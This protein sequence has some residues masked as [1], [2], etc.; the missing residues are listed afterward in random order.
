M[1]RLV[2]FITRHPKSVIAFTLLFIG[3][4][5]APL[6]R[7]TIDP[8]MLSLIDQNDPDLV[9]MD[10]IDEIFGGQDIAIISVAAENAF[11]PRILQIVDSLTQAIE[12]MDYVDRVTSIT[13]VEIIRGANDFMSVDPFLEVI[14]SSQEEQDSLGHLAAQE[15][16][17]QD[18]L[19]SDDQ[20]HTAILVFL[21]EGGYDEV[22]YRQF[23]SFTDRYQSEDVIIELGGMPIIRY[24]ISADIEHDVVTFIPLGMSLMVILLFFS[25]RSWRGVLLPMGVVAM[26]IA[27]TLGLM[28]WLDISLKIVTNLVP[29]MLIAI[30]NAYG[31]HILARYYEDV[32]EL[33]AGAPIHDII[34]R[35]IKHI[36][37]PILLA[38]V[39][40]IAGFLSLLSHVLPASREVGILSAFGIA[41]SFILS[42]T[43]IPAVLTLLRRPSATENIHNDESRYISRV[44]SH[45]GDAVYHHQK[46][47]LT[48]FIGLTIIAA[49]GI[50][51]IVVDSNPLNYYEK[52]SEIHRISTVINENYGGSSS[53]SVVVEGDIREPVVLKQIEAIQSYL[54]T[55]PDIG[56][57]MS[58]VDFIKE[59]NAAM[60]NN[61]PRYYRIPESRDLVAQYL[62]L[63]SFESS[64][65][66]LDTYVDYEYYQ[67][68]V[69]IRIS[70]FDVD[71]M[72]VI[73][74]KLNQFLDENIRVDNQP[75]AE[76]YAVL[77]AHLIP[78]MVNGQIRS[79]FV[80]L[81]FVA[82][83]VG[84]F[85][86]SGMAA[87][88]SVLPLTTGV[89]SVFGLM[90]YFDVYL[91]AGTSMLSSIVVGV[92]IDYTI[93]FLYRFRLE[94]RQGASDLDALHTTLKTTG[95]GILFNAL[96][97]M[98]GFSVNMLSNFLPIYFFGWL[99]L[100]SILVCTIGAM[101]LLPGLIMQIRP[102][103]VYG[104]RR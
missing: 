70:T 89:V 80:S 68:Q 49:F 1:K 59:M 65:G 104:E 7:L 67:A 64:E 39:T 47:T 73:E 16:L 87:L 18:I 41:L 52:G 92:G 78:M 62:L 34:Y 4:M 53:M 6:G 75:K 93:H 102:K 58:I 3:V 35:G 22:L 13:N 15:K 51:Q 79:L 17:I 66:T 32:R 69:V 2:E 88:F 103:F 91:N 86:R 33:G 43:F 11:H 50:P 23:K 25:F 20:T 90:G 84:L 42:I 45:L 36:S 54:D 76:G 29:V 96:A 5:A 26:S 81:F 19:I 21:S 24:H 27:A 95:Q 46:L 94:I 37:T 38:G 40:T 98:V 31:I 61:D 74:N 63:Y 83:I 100:V 14:P 9:R 56:Y 71:R 85:F 12:G 55:L 30:A 8:D 82:V 28:A 97:V 48:I 77:I 10:E 57:T 60:H 72:V 99:I 101:T 44:L